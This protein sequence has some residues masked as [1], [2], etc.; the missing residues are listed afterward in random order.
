MT[1]HEIQQILENRLLNLNETRKAA[2]NSGL[3]DRVVAL[4]I[5]ITSTEMSLQKIKDT[6]DAVSNI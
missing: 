1:L 4:D 3:L 2:V 5:D 6:L